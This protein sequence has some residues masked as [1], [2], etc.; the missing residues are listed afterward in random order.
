[1]AGKKKSDNVGKAEDA[2]AGAVLENRADRM[3]K[4]TAGLPEPDKTY[5][6]VIR[7]G[8]KS[9]KVCRKTNHPGVG[10]CSTLVLRLKNVKGRWEA[11][12]GRI[13][14]EMRKVLKDN[15]ISL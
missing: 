14:P 1:M 12:I 4:G 15:N 11:A 13:T 9:I 3:A 7:D 8:Q 10:V 6:T 2:P 5:Y